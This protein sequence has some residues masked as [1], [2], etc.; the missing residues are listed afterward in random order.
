[1]VI[2]ITGLLKE[3]I[4][5]KSSRYWD[6]LHRYYIEKENMN[7]CEDKKSR[8]I[9]AESVKEIYDKHGYHK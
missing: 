3:L 6:E 1:M 7:Y 4:F 8:T 5:L 9:F 2:I